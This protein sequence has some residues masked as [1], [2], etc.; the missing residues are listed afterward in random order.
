MPWVGE[1]GREG[2]RREGGGGK[3][4]EG[5]VWVEFKCFTERF[6]KALQHTQSAQR[7]QGLP[8]SGDVTTAT[9]N[10]CHTCHL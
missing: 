6:S 7:R 10:K 2:R 3:E 8:L 1:E 4:V 5:G 9:N